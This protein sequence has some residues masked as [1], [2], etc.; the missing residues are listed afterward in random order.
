MRFMIVACFLTLFLLGCKVSSPVRES[1]A[2]TGQAI[3]WDMANA[4][5]RAD[6]DAYSRQLDSEAEKHGNQN[7][8]AIYSQ[9]RRRLKRVEL[10][11][12]EIK[13]EAE[14]GEAYYLS[15]PSSSGVSRTKRFKI[16][17][18]EVGAQQSTLFASVTII[19][20]PETNTNRV[21]RIDLNP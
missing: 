10:K 2:N 9:L 17:V 16:L 19:F 12:W 4:V 1:D 20:S 7:Y 13:L 11:K 3:V 6:Y 8:S 15:A 14:G 21:R 5:Y 18:T